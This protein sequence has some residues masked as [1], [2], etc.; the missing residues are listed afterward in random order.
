VPE[1]L[2]AGVVEAGVVGAGVV[3]P[4]LGG[5]LPGAGVVGGVVVGVVG[6]VVGGVVVGGVGVGVGGTF[7]GWHCQTTGELVTEPPTPPASMAVAARLCGAAAALAARPAVR[8]RNV[9]PVMRPIAAGRTRAK[10]M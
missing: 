4:P 2:A 1:S 6:G 8:V 5:P 9:P 3:E 7:T 10:H